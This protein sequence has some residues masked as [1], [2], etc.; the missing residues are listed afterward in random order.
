MTEVGSPGPALALYNCVLELG[1]QNSNPVL[2]VLAGET[3]VSKH[4]YPPGDHLEFGTEGWR[5]F[6][7]SHTSPEQTVDEHGHF[8]LFAPV[9]DSVGKKS[10]THV[11]A[12]SMDGEGQPLRW[13]T[14]NRWVTDGIWLGAGELLQ[15]L[16]A[17]QE[18]PSQSLLARWLTAMVALY[19]PEI[20]MV[21]FERDRQLTRIN[22]SPSGADILE[23]REIYLLAE[24]PI[25]LL[26]TLQSKLVN[27]AGSD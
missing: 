15:I 9:V 7:H 2:Q 5:A 19:K 27:T 1:E 24:K 23:N 22:D 25:D 21:L 12:L 20:E 3:P 6:Y 16:R 8:H 13:F 18:K 17:Q 10:W 26:A 14:V 4:K 11:V